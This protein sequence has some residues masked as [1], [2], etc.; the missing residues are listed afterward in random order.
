MSNGEKIPVVRFL[1]LSGMG[2]R[3]ECHEMIQSKRVTVNDQPADSGTPVDPDKD[4]VKIDGEVIAASTEFIYILLNKP[5][6]YLVSDSDPEGRPLAKD[7]LP[8]FG[9]RLFSVGRLD[10]QS[11]GMLLFTNDGLWA[12]RIAHP[13]NRV[14]KTYLAKVRNVPSPETLRRWIT[15]IRQDRQIMKAED[16]RIHKTTGQN[17]WL[18]VTLSGGVNRQVRRMGRATGHPV[19]KLLRIAVGNV[20]LGDLPPAHF[21]F[22]EPREIKALRHPHRTPK[23]T[24]DPK[25]ANIYVPSRG[26]DKKRIAAMR[27]KRRASSR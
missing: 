11:E 8:D 5:R 24:F 9:V 18:L 7:L 25:S 2:S 26:K 17:A 14:L 15:G 16:V 6:G 21:R 19:V 3:R 4:S 20:F 13:R 23:I 12:D 10:F 27:R 1:A 22:L